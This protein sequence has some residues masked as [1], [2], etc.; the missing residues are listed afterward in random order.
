MDIDKILEDIGDVPVSQISEGQT[1]EGKA[2]MIRVQIKELEKKADKGNAKEKIEA[3]QLELARINAEIEKKKD[4]PK[5]FN[6]RLFIA[7][8]KELSRQKKIKFGDIE[9]ASGTSIGYISRLDKPNNTND[10]SA[11]FIAT[12]S[13]MLDV[14]VDDLMHK[15]FRQPTPI[16]SD[17]EQY[18]VN[19]LN[20]LINE[21]LSDSLMW[22]TETK[23]YLTSIDCENSGLGPYVPHPLFDVEIIDEGI[24]E[25]S[26]YPTSS[27][28]AVYISRFHDEGISSINGPG[29][30]AKLTG[31]DATI[32]IMN[33]V[34]S[35]SKRRAFTGTVDE[36]EKE[37][38]IADREGV[39]SVC[40]TTTSCEEIKKQI[41]TLYNMLYDNYTKVGV[42]TK[43][44]LLIND[45]MGATAH[46]SKQ[47]GD[48]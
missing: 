30:Y 25:T 40:S 27:Y 11:E 16:L 46:P 29:F 20:R 2:A 7:N 39:E 5:N 14:P 18:I 41:N 15:D 37:I 31:T 26:G 33:I 35:N 1:L 23:K 21:T 8:V 42:S 34:H 17:S 13:K 47:G 19:F 9:Y 3:L 24:D 36:G 12:A 4:K 38:Y 32:Y 28:K 6:K 45:F 22:D 44:R 48:K 43:S 10:P